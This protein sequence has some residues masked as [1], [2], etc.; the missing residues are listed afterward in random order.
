M[1]TN[2]DDIRSSMS[3]DIAALQQE[4]SRLQK[5]ISAQG[6]EAYYELR[7]RAG[8]ALD[9]ATPRAKRAVAQIRAEGAAV[10]DAA[11]EHP[12]ATTTAFALV[13]AIAFLAGYMMAGHSQPQPRQ[14]WQR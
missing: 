13:G 12:T 2:T 1:A 3:K 8:K 11:R 4:V 6:T 7:D 14:W 10:A 9:D 5:M